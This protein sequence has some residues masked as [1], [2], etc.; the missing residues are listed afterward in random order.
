MPVK[1]EPDWKVALVLLS[2]L[3]SHEVTIFEII[4]REY[5]KFKIEFH[6]P[7]KSCLMIFAQACLATLLRSV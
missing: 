3:I 5:L 4:N 2:N 7:L 1:V 6:I